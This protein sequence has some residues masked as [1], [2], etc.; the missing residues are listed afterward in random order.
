MNKEET[1]K[2]YAPMF[3]AACAA[4]NFTFDLT[5]TSCECTTVGCAYEREDTCFAYIGFLA[6]HGTHTQT[7]RTSNR[8]G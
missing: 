3:A 6:A 5:P 7:A 8:Q 4:N 1:Y 2:R